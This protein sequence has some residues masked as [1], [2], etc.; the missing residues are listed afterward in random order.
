MPSQAYW[1][2]Q[3]K[4]QGCKHLGI[5]PG[6]WSYIKRIGTHLNWLYTEACNGNEYPHAEAEWERKAKTF[7]YHNHLEIYL[8]TDPRGATIYLDKQPIP[9]NNY[10]R[11][12]CV[13]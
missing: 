2:E 5:T 3:R 12:V 11:A 10:T 7:A 8:Q 6:Q 4:Q 9:E 13:Y 1:N